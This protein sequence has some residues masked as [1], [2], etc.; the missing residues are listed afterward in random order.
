MTNIEPTKPALIQDCIAKRQLTQNGSI[1]QSDNSISRI[2]KDPGVRILVKAHIIHQNFTSRPDI[3]EVFVNEID[4][5]SRLNIND[6]EF[7]TRLKKFYDASKDLYTTF[8]SD[9]ANRLSER[10]R[11]VKEVL[12]NYKPK[13]LLDVGCGSGEIANDL[14]NSL[15]IPCNTTFGLE[16][17][18]DGDNKKP[19]QILK[20]DGINF[21]FPDNSFDFMT[22]FSVLHHVEDF[23]G[24]IKE[25]KRV[26]KPNGHL[27]I[28][29]CDAVSKEVKMFNLFMDNIWYKVYTPEPNV[30]L[31]NNCYS[32][33]EWIEIFKNEGF[34]FERL[35][36]PEPGNSYRPVMM[37]FEKK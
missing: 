13:S 12:G 36:F 17:I 31:P 33:H 26:L 9:R 16:I 14:M 11:Q 7:F 24:V 2:W 4:T 20:Y 21:P 6:E 30:P 32:H 27:L 28:R 5:L 25:A 29:E 34:S 18:V 3:G 35:T 23:N 8:S 22:M 37:L 10:S 1:L 19:F 15:S